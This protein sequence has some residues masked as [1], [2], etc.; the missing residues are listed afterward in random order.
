M[1]LQ[2]RTQKCK[3]C[4]QL[5]TRNKRGKFVCSIDCEAVFGLVLAEKNKRIEA[6]RQASLDRLDTATRK[7]K[8]KKNTQ[9]ADDVQKK[10]NSYVKWRDWGENCIS[11]NKPHTT[12]GVRN[13]SHF[14]SRGASSFLR[15]NLWNIHM[16]CYRCNAKQG[17]NILEY[18][19]KLMQK[20]GPEKV[21]F[22]MSAPKSR[23]YTK[24]YLVRFKNVF[25]RKS[26]RQEAR[27]KAKSQLA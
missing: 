16:S 17:G 10:V 15:F 4:R 12:V 9:Y 13:A 27:V 5:C 25:H 11:C 26:K 23:E 20:I 21:D 24:E 14:K 1:S 19:P 18:L 6:K 22:L 7:A 8:S 2:A 3:T